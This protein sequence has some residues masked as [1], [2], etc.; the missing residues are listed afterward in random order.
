MKIVKPIINGVEVD[1]DVLFDVINPANEVCFAQCADSGAQHVDSA[2]DAAKCAFPDWSAESDERR[3]ELLMALAEKLETHQ[4]ELINLVVQ[5][6]GKPVTGLNFVGATM[7]VGGAIAWLK[8]TAALKLPVDLIQD[9]DN[10]RIEV[11]RRPLGVVASITPWNWPLMIAIWHVIPALKAGNTLV[12][13][14]SPLTPV[15]T[16]RF[17]EL[18]N[19][20]LPAGV[21]NLATGG[22]QTGQALISHPGVNKI[23]FT[24][25]TATGKQ[26]MATAAADLK[27]ITLELGGNDA[28]IVL[29]DADIE[30]IAPKLFGACFHNNGQTCA[31]L[32]RL[33]VHE[34]VYDKVCEE[35][36]QI[37][38]QIKVGDGLLPKSD[39]GPLQNK[40]QLEKVESLINDA[41]ARGAELLH[42]G[43]RIEG[44]GYFYQPTLIG[45][46]DDSFSLVAQEQFGPAVPIIK[47][48]S[49]E[50]VVNIANSNDSGLGASIWSSD[51]VLAELLA[52][53]MQA[54][55]VWINDHGAIQ[56]N[57][58]FGGIKQSGIG[59]EF[60]LYGL[61][62]YTWLQTVKLS[63]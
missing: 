14:P 63:K 57:A 54:G 16:H 2:V 10:A 37:A 3:T 43:A 55:S 60:G 58:P 38:Q 26:I 48:Q 53:R 27:R 32:K 1:T 24:G 15:A 61:E 21:L 62:E 31:C 7:E 17:I 59:V 56:P 40:M 34:S 8:A 28:G 33:Y 12:I 44:P 49:I 11:H 22:G 13:K 9:D 23:V 39:L 25:S 51:I 18:A 6:T 19:E 41:L 50:E 35:L 5:E 46:I 42:G 30:A 52:Q 47:Y 4:A 36:T 20:V 45:N 29:P